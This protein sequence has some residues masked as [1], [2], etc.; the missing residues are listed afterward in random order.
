[1]DEGFEWLVEGLQYDPPRTVHKFIS[2]DAPHF[3]DAIEKAVLENKIFFS[4]VANL[5]DP[6]EARP[7]YKEDS[8]AQV[9]EYLKKW[10]RTFGK[11]TTIT[12]GNAYELAK[13]NGLSGFDLA[14]NAEKNSGYSAEYAK[15]LISK[16]KAIL[17]DS[18]NWTSVTSFTLGWS[19]PLFWAHYANSHN[20]V[21]LEYKV[22]PESMLQGRLRLVPVTYSEERPVVSTIELLKRA[23]AGTGGR[24]KELITPQD[25][26][27]TVTKLAL[28]KPAEWSYEQEFRLVDTKGSNARTYQAVPSLA[29]NRIYIG[30]NVASETREKIRASFGKSVEVVQVGLCDRA[31][32]LKYS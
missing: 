27:E 20:G 28:T 12:G 4:P 21:C 6:F 31:F 25:L 3:W 18:R 16:A 15:F 7:V 14:V 23:G 17:E 29:V 8:V 2:A 19:S 26:G 32:S 11:G 24:A 22:D 1:M 30:T 5:N 13:E 10:E 9:Q